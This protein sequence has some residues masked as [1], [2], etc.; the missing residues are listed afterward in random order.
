MGH[1]AIQFPV[2]RCSG[3][4]RA[5]LSGRIVCRF[6]GGTNLQEDSLP[7]EA[8]L[9][10]YTRI[11]VPPVEFVEQ[12]PYVVLVA[13]MGEG[14]RVTGRLLGDQEAELPIGAPLQFVRRDEI[15]AW[16]APVQESATAVGQA[17][18]EDVMQ[19]C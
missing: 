18:D 1:D 6:C 16:F 5:Q 11:R 12:A 19:P 15:A 8:V 2:L 10:T 4:G 7:P 3:C 9:E 13:R 14:V 17:G